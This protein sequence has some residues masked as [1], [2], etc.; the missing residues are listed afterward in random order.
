MIQLA[1]SIPVLPTETTI[2]SVR[3]LGASSLCVDFKN[4]DG[5]QTLSIRVYRRASPTSD[6][7]LIGTLGLDAI[8][9]G[10]TGSLNLEIGAECDIRFT[11]TASGIGLTTNFAGALR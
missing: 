3:V 8:G 2:T 11:G 10:A 6:Y 7:S 1:A 9:P 4:T 5:S